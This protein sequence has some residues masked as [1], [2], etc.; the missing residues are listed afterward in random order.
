MLPL[1]AIVLP[2]LVLFSGLAID[3]G[4]MENRRLAM[5]HAADAAALAAELEIER[6]TG[7][8]VSVAKQV[9]ALNGFTDG[10][11]NT[12]VTVAMRPANGAY[13]GNYDALQVSITQRAN[14]F[15]FYAIPNI[16]IA[17]TSKALV[18]PCVY[19]NG[20]STSIPTL[21]AQNSALFLNCPLYAKGN[22]SLNAVSLAA[23]AVDLTGP[24]GSLSGGAYLTHPPRYN[25]AVMADPLASLPQP[26]FTSCTANN[27]AQNGGTATLYPGVFCNGFTLTNTTVTLAPGLYVITGGA[28][29]SNSTVRGSGVTLFFTQGGGSGYGQFLIDHCQ[30]VTL[31]APADASQGAIPAMLVFGDRSWIATAPQ[32]VQ[33]TDSSV[34]GDGVWYTT[35]TGILL[36]NSLMTANRYLA[37]D[38][39]S[40]STN[41]A[42]LVTAQDFSS[43]TTGSPFRPLGGVVE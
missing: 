11:S 3:V 15:F 5:Q 17:V 33:I 19:L 39:D 43:V 20:P 27:F 35:G 7:N 40:L 1:F 12:S 23:L 2:I 37:L 31:S 8:M 26:A 13:A 9:A 32:D 36:A 41:S 29:W 28:H 38:T 22:S 42:L 24:T 6:N 25:A 4:M 14:A 18:P 21:S 30:S 16:V 34:N 10:A